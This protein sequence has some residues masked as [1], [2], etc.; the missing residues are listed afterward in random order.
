MI[1]CYPPAQY[2]VSTLQFPTFLLWFP[3]S[4]GPV[5]PFCELFPVHLPRLDFR[6]DA[7]TACSLFTLRCGDWALLLISPTQFHEIVVCL[8]FF[9]CRRSPRS[10]WTLSGT[11]TCCTPISTSRTATP[12]LGSSSGTSPSMLPFLTLRTAVGLVLYL[13]LVDAP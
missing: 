13:C 4:R 1:N 8:D 2:F 11:L 7:P 9:F 12:S 10:L 3:R 6:V 5:I